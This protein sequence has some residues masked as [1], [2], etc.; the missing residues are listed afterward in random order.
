MQSESGRISRSEDSLAPRCHRARQGGLSLPAP[1][2]PSATRRNL[3]FSGIPRG[4]RRSLRVSLIPEVAVGKRTPA[5]ELL[6]NLPDYHRLELRVLLLDLFE[7]LR[8][9]QYEGLPLLLLVLF[10]NHHH[11]RGSL[12]LL[13]SK[14]VPSE[15]QQP[16]QVFLR[17]LL[18]IELH[19]LILLGLYRKTGR[20]G[21][22]EVFHEGIDRGPFLGFGSNKHFRAVRSHSDILTHL[23]VLENAVDELPQG[24]PNSHL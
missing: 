17:K 14:I 12:K 22:V 15:F 20:L 3:P 9:F 8:V 19:F 1:S 13:R 16:L 21:S 24:F 11:N 18:G 10:Q 7:P 6:N 5:N 2:S 4:Q 23:R